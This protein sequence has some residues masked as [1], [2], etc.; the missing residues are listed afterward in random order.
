M[1]QQCHLEQQPQ[2]Q[3]EAQHYNHQDNRGRG[4]MRPRYNSYRGNN[5]R[6]YNMGRGYTNNYQPN[7]GRGHIGGSYGRNFNRSYNP[8]LPRRPIYCHFCKQP[9]HVL[10]D[11]IL[12]K[13][14]DSGYTNGFNPNM[15]T[16]IVPNPISQSPYAQTRAASNSNHS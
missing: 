6:G 14:H 7:P 10:K 3:G 8:R 15:Q 4:N 16:P 2:Y 12:K 5:G 13:Q 9:N 11:C 1:K